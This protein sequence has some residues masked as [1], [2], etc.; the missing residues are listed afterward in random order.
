MRYQIQYSL[1]DSQLV[2]ELSRHNDFEVLDVMLA[3]SETTG[4][5]FELVCKT[6]L[7]KYSRLDDIR[8]YYAV[9]SSS[10]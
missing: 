2:T 3:I 6:D 4:L 1:S 5:D 10:L 9:S 7:S 8:E